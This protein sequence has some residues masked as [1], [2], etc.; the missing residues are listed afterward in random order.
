MYAENSDLRLTNLDTCPP[1]VGRSV[2][3]ELRGV[4]LLKE[5]C[6]QGWS[7]KFQKPPTMLS[8]PLSFW[9]VIG[10]QAIRSELLPPPCLHSTLVDSNPLEPLSSK[11][12]AF[13]K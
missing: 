1:P 3:E 2:W 8:V 10:D 11:L 13:L 5:A 9:L 6:Q 7:L 4:F 12:N